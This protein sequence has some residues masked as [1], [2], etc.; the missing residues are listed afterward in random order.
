MKTFFDDDD[1]P[2][3]STTGI[4]STH[5]HIYIIN[6]NTNLHLFVNFSIVIVNVGEVILYISLPFFH[7]HWISFG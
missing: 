7:F 5:S 1:K 4:L 2:I 6:Y 3:D